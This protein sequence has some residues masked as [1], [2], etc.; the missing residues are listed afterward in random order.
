LELTLL[1][2]HLAI[3]RLN[4]DTPLPSWAQEGTFSS[5]TRTVHELSVVCA[6]HLIPGDVQ[7][8]HDWRCLGVAGPLDFALT[9]ILAGLAAPLADAG[10]SI[11]A[12]STFD[13]DYLLVKQQHLQQ[14]VE[15]LV[16]SGY[17]VHAGDSR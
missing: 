4:P 10:I 6:E 8:E 15:V 5:I 13:T 7:C 2:D 11:F 16:H 17:I 3:C 14:A 12:I 9:G 1:P